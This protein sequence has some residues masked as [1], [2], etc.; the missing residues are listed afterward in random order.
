[1]NVPFAGLEPAASRLRG[2]RSQPDELERRALFPW[3]GNHLDHGNST[4]RQMTRALNAF[5]RMT[6]PPTRFVNSSPIFP[7]SANRSTRR[8]TRMPAR[9]A[10][11]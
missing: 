11:M 10:I 2:G 9:S 4:V 5:G 6:P 8:C 3:P 1:M 7:S